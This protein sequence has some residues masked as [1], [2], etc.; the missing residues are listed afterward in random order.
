[1][2]N[3]ILNPPQTWLPSMWDR[4]DGSRQITLE[5]T[6]LTTQLMINYTGGNNVGAGGYVT[7]LEEYPTSPDVE[8]SEQCTITHRFNCDYATG[9]I[10]QSAYPRGQLMVDSAGNFTRVLS[11]RLAPNGRQGPL[12]CDLTVT[13]EAQSFANPP[14]NLML[15]WLK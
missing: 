10:V 12:S 3:P 6:R 14:M 11:T 5:L 1:M 13:S 4:A 9:Q 7:I 15:K 8:F 2:S